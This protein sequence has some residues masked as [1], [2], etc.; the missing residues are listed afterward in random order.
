MSS[1]FQEVG[2][3]FTDLAGWRY[4]TRMYSSTPPCAESLHHNRSV[5]SRARNTSVIRAQIAAIECQHYGA[6]P[7]RL[8]VIL[9]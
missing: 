5:F 8:A 9:C 6:R 3:P 4:P 2:I 1:N 7:I